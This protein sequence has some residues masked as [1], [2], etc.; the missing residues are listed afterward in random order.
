[1][2]VPVLRGLGQRRDVTT[3]HQELSNSTL[4]SLGNKEHGLQFGSVA[5]TGGAGGPLVGITTCAEGAGGFKAWKQGK[6]TTLTPELSVNCSRILAGSGTETSQVKEAVSH[7]KNVISYEEM[8]GRVQNCSWLVE[9]FTR[10]LFTSA[11]EM[12]FPMAF[13]FVVHDS[14]QQ[15]LRLLRLLY[16]PHNTYCIHYDSKSLFKEFFDGIA[17]C[18]DNVMIASRT[19]NVVW[20]YYT[21][22]QAQMNCLSDLLKYRNFQKHKWKYVINLCGKEL[23]LVTNKEMVVKMMRLKGSSSIVTQPCANKKILVQQRLVH[24]VTLNKKGTDI[25]MDKHKYLEDRPF[26]LTLYHKS[27]SYC[28]LSFQFANYLVFNSSALKF[29]EFFKKTRNA[30]EHFYATSLEFQEGTKVISAIT[31]L[32]CLGHTGLK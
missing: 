22:L 28:A 32:K 11:L 9:Y 16:R 8:L 21:I 31:I 20:G 1:V 12:S 23:P 6:V 26:N 10:N 25:V 30:E 7:W 15:V 19:E 17:R 2:L 29:Y 5:G 3:I 18:F 4:V 27:S 14:P 13:T 24:P